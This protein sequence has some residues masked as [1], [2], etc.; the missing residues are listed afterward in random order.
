MRKRVL[1]TSVLIRHWQQCRDRARRGPSQNGVRKWAHELIKIH[2]SDAI[3]TPVVLEL[4]AGVTSDRE[5]V[6]TKAFLAEFNCID[7]GHV[8]DRDWVN[9][10]RLAQR[11]PADRRRRNLGDCLIRAIADRLHHDVLSFDKGFVR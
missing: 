11:V 6:I 9:A 8:T 1:D 10:I 4:L 7:N 5:L 3:V 2:S